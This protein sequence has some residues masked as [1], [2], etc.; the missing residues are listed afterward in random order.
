MNL[1]ISCVPNIEV[2]ETLHV[3]AETIQIIYLIVSKV[4][5]HKTL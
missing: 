5:G 2:L 3:G 1:C 4:K